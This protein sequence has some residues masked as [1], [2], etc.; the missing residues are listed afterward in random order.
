MLEVIG[1]YNYVIIVSAIY[2]IIL[3]ICN[4]KRKKET[5]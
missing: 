2:L 5:D 4:L 3:G 1:E